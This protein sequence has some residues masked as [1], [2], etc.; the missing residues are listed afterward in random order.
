MKIRNFN[1][2][3]INNM[4]SPHTKI[5]LNMNNFEDKKKNNVL[6][7]KT[8]PILMNFIENNEPI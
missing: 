5:L 2:I 1:N 3:I 7:D 4:Y 8:I 6:N